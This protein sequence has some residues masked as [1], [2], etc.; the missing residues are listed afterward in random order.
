MQVIVSP[1]S[2]Q[3]S[4]QTNSK[5]SEMIF[6]LKQSCRQET[7]CPG[8]SVPGTAAFMMKLSTPALLRDSSI[9]CL[10][11]SAAGCWRRCSAATCRSSANLPHRS[12]PTLPWWSVS[13]HP[14]QLLIHLECYSTLW[15]LL[16]RNCS[17]SI[18]AIYLLF[19]SSNNIS[20]FSLG[21]CAM[22]DIL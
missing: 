10:W 22:S 14:P 19:E 5:L 13:S 2:P 21:I 20:R 8:T 7:L 11:S 18:L 15:L 12:N 4:W 9:F 16:V 3:Y 17:E 6:T 1:E